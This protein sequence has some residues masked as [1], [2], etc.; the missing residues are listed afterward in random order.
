M[1]FADSLEV[2]R[3]A[4][5]QLA[6]TGATEVA[7]LHEDLNPLPVNDWKSYRFVLAY[8]LPGSD[9]RTEITFL[10]LDEKQ[11]LMLRTTAD[12]KQFGVATSRAF[13]IIR[14]WHEMLPGEDDPARGN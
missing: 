1:K 6:P 3:K 8:K 4:V 11:Q 5:L 10:N 7:I 9:L 2:Y 14:S 12:A 13:N